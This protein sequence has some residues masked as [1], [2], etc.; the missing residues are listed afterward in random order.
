MPGPFA[1]LAPWPEVPLATY[2]EDGTAP[3]PTGRYSL[4][5]QTKAWMEM[6]R[7]DP[8]AYCGRADEPSTLDH[9]V[10]IKRGAWDWSKPTL[11]MPDPYGWPNLTAA[12]WSCNT[13]KR[14]QS[15]LAFLARA[16]WALPRRRNGAQT[17]RERYALAPKP[18]GGYKYGRKGS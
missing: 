7:R 11:E 16:P 14:R 9:I 3:C 17:H 1:D 4:D 15:L 2:G 8:C 13:T 6:L 5:P 18:P 10:P 12:C